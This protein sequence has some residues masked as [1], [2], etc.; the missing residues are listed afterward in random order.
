M[1]RILLVVVGAVVVVGLGTLVIGTM[2]WLRGLIGTRVVM[3][4]PAIVVGTLLILVVAIYRGRPR[5]LVGFGIVGGLLL[6]LL[7]MSERVLGL[8]VRALRKR[9]GG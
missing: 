4:M 6:G 7:I 1:S 5:S 3:I 8:S 9:I 2:I